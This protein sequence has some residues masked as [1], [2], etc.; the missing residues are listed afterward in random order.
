LSK[1]IY[2]CT[3]IIALI[4]S[5]P[6]ISTNFMAST[7]YDYVIIGAGGAGLHLAL[8]MLEDAWFIDKKILLLDIQ[9]ITVD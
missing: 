2:T 8:A 1:L 4:K 3:V 5:L 7:I 6:K 9:N